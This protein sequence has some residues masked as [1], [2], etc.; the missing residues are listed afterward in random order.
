VWCLTCSCYGNS[1]SVKGD[2]TTEVERIE[3]KPRTTVD[4]TD[5]KKEM[6]RGSVIWFKPKQ[7]SGEGES[8]RKDEDVIRLKSP[9][10]VTYRRQNK[11]LHEQTEKGSKI[12]Q[13]DPSSQ[14]SKEIQ[15]NPK[16]NS[17]TNNIKTKSQNENQNGRKV[18]K[19]DKDLSNVENKK[20]NKKR[21]K[22]NGENTRTNRNRKKNR[23]QATSERTVD[24]KSGGT[25]SSPRGKALDVNSEEQNNIKQKKQKQKKQKSKSEQ[26]NPGENETP[27]SDEIRKDTQEVE[28]KSIK[29]LKN[30][31]EEQK[32][33][34]KQ[35]E[36]IRSKPSKADES[37]HANDKNKNDIEKE[38][39]V[40]NADLLGLLLAKSDP[41]LVKVLIDNSSPENLNVFLSNS[42]IT[43][44]ELK[45]IVAY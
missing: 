23:Q 5:A 17:E 1:L 45:D 26:S 13:I 38:K 2:E 35:E 7:K 8:G 12:K 33:L 37:N 36:V 15:V 41:E 42:K 6:L 11:S 20:R 32:H 3:F 24:S 10:T 4:L 18:Q 14:G 29:Q 40:Q 31:M 21:R 9:K 27:K 19:S 39:I 30:K 22:N 43:I 28:S 16:V 34:E 44:E 25:N